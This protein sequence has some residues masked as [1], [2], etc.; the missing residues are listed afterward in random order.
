M[1]ESPTVITPKVHRKL[2]VDLFKFVWTLL[3]KQKRTRAEDDLMIHA[4]HASRYHWGE[5]GAPENLARGEWQC[6]RVY[7]VLKRA[8]PAQYHA[9][10]CLDLCVEHHLVDFDRAYAFEALARAAAVAG[11]WEEKARYLELAREA[12]DMIAELDDRKH[13]KDD[14]A[15]IPAANEF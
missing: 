15:T 13:F 4:A 10:R 8:E 5:V 6:S 9:Q 1:E 7:A 12:E 11:D 2:A 14:L 3:E